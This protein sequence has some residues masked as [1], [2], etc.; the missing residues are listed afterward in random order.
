MAVGRFLDWISG[1]VVR[2]MGPSP[3]DRAAG[4]E[5]ATSTRHFTRRTKEVV[6][7][8][9]S[10]TATLMRAGEVEAANRLLAEVEQ[11][12]LAEEAVLMERVAEVKAER[13]LDR[14]AVTRLRLARA[15]AVAMLGSTVLAS[16]AVGMAVVGLFRDESGELGRRF[17]IDE[18]QGDPLNTFYRRG[19]IK[20]LNVAGVDLKMTPSELRRYRQLTA[21]G[22]TDEDGLESFL[23]GLLPTPLAEKVHLALVMASEQLPE[24]V[25]EET[26]A[27]SESLNKER[28]NATD[29]KP[30]DQ[31][32]PDPAD[33]PSPEPSPSESDKNGENP[34]DEGDSQDLPIGQG[35]SAL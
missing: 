18:V 22:V 24:P 9:L 20:H 17:D 4:F 33:N 11:D 3:E 16:S 19:Q 29:D 25:K 12:V 31:E 14:R 21:G 28:K 13:S 34:D 26:A 30:E 35:D 8:K 23:L 27:L 2:L 32:T 7:D 15:M 5:L 10:F 6:D 1:T